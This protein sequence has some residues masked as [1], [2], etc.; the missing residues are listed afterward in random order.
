MLRWRT[1]S[2]CDEA[3]GLVKLL[4]CEAGQSSDDLVACRSKS[5]ISEPGIVSER[6]LA[7]DDN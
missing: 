4:T 7:S 1:L 6:D 3:W 2:E 5:D